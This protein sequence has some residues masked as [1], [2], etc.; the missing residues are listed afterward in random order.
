[1]S[2]IPGAPWPTTDNPTANRLLLAKHGLKTISWVTESMLDQ[3]GKLDSLALDT[4]GA[5]LAA[6]CGDKWRRVYDALKIDYNPLENYNMQEQGGTVNDDR[7]TTDGRDQSQ[8]SA[9]QTTQTHGA[10]R[11][12]D[13][14]NT[15]V[16]PG[17]KTEIQKAA[18]DTSTRAQLNDYGAK[19]LTIRDKVTHTVDE[20]VNA[21]E[22]P[23]DVKTTRT[24]TSPSKYYGFGTTSPAS[25]AES[26]SAEELVE[27]IKGGVKLDKRDATNIDDQAATHS[28]AQRTDSVDVTDTQDIGQRETV[29]TEEESQQHEQ[30]SHSEQAYE[31]AISELP[32]DDVDIRHG[33][34]VAHR[35]GH[36]RLERSGNIGVTTSQQMLEQELAVRRTTF[37]SIVLDDI[38]SLMTIPIYHL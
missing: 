28:E 22:T 34:T 37:W 4:L 12:E 24:P 1:M 36:S 10:R 14:R 5:M 3:T 35:E 19:T 31:D 8:K 21:D 16:N 7:E 13:E 20:T 30:T 32:T 18:K 17:A 11:V 29:H 15:T 25:V 26:E 27:H 6:E 33:E 2:H 9:R 23:A 38:A